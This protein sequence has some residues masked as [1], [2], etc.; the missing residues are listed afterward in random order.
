MLND[1]SDIPDII[2]AFDEWVLS[3]EIQEAFI[4]KIDKYTIAKKAFVAGFL[5]GSGFEDEKN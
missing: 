5:A 1:K 2:K 4:T 3:P